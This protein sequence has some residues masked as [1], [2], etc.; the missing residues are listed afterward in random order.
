MNSAEHTR[1]VSQADELARRRKQ[2][3]R[4]LEAHRLYESVRCIRSVRIFMEHHVICVFDFMTLLKRLQAQLT[5]VGT[6]WTPSDDPAAT[7]LINSIVLDEE[8]D[9]AFGPEPSSHYSWYLAAMEEVGADTGPM[10]ELESRIRGGL[11]PGAALTGCGLPP[12]AEAFARTTFDSAARPPH[13]VAAAFVYGRENIIPGMFVHLVRKL[14]DAGVPCGLLVDYLERHIEV[15]SE[16]H[17]PAAEEML[18]RI[19]AGDDARRTEAHRAGLRALHAREQLWE[20]AAR[21]CELAHERPGAGEGIA[22]SPR[23]VQRRRHR[24]DR[25][26]RSG[27]GS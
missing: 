14:A 22:R 25:G 21:A 24:E 1:G 17:G 6:P 13:V 19:V 10:R 16:D 3:V 26:S 11:E 7:R 12:A 2:A 20:A 4:R 15:D 9:D 8:S 5:C 23:L 27:R 18:Q